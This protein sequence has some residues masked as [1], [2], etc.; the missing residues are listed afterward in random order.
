MRAWVEFGRTGPLKSQ[1]N[2]KVKFSVFLKLHSLRCWSLL[3][4][5]SFS[6]LTAASCHLQLTSKIAQSIFILIRW[7]YFGIPSGELPVKRLSFPNWPPVDLHFCCWSEHVNLSENI[8]QLKIEL[9]KI[10]E[11][12]KNSLNEEEMRKTLS[13]VMVNIKDPSLHY[14]SSCSSEKST[15]TSFHC[16]SKSS[17]V[18]WTD[19]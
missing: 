2:A 8:S 4:V 17:S 13:Y 7:F 14:V 9:I 3:T 10:P 5:R 15:K 12:T 16:D 1:Q 18:T 11:T 19:N 6:G